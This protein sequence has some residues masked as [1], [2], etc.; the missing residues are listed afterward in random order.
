MLVA[1][2]LLCLVGVEKVISQTC[3]DFSIDNIKLMDTVNIT[4]AISANCTTQKFTMTVSGPA[5]LWWGVA[6]GTVMIGSDAFLHTTGDQ[7]TDPISIYE[8]YLQKKTFAKIKHLRF[9]FILN[10]FVC[11][12]TVIMSPQCQKQNNGNV[13]CFYTAKNKPQ[14]V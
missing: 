12:S 4:T 6:F 14:P 10:F 7:N 5:N 13:H 9:I 2:L 11:L 3:Y 1:I 8:Y